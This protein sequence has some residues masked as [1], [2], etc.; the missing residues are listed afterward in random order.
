MRSHLAMTANAGFSTTGFCNARRGQSHFPSARQ[1]GRS[2]GLPHFAPWHLQQPSQG[3]T[4]AVG[5]PLPY[6]S[7]RLTSAFPQD[8]DQGLHKIR[9]MGQGQSKTGS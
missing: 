6:T 5:S 9:F 2:L 1:L 3:T 4:Q 8:R 7:A